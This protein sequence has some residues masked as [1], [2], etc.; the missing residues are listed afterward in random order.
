[1][2]SAVSGSVAFFARARNN[3]ALRRVGSEQHARGERVMRVCAPTL[4]ESTTR[5]SSLWSA[6]ALSLSA[7]VIVCCFT[8][9]KAPLDKRSDTSRP[10]L[11]WRR[12][13]LAIEP[14]RVTRTACGTVVT[15]CRRPAAFCAQSGVSALNRGGSRAPS[16][17]STVDALPARWSVCSTPDQPNDAPELEC[18]GVAQYFPVGLS[19]SV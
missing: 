16:G 4:A 14:R 17:A 3:R 19:H 18:F 8:R 12:A 5:R 7:G 11:F 1:M 9:P 10:L 13:R 6:V 2:E 15:P